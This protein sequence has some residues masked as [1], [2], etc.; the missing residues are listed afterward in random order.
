MDFP[1]FNTNIEVEEVLA[2]MR[3]EQEK[4]LAATQFTKQN[5]Y[6]PNKY[7]RASL[8]KDED[9][10][11]LTIRLLPF[12]PEGGSP[13]KKIFMHT[14]RVSSEVAKSTWKTIACPKHNEE[15]ENKNCPF[16]EMS[17]MAKQKSRE[18]LDEAKK[19][20]LDDLS[21]VNRASEMWLVR[22]I[23]RGKENEGVKF[24]LFPNPKKGGVFQD[25]MTIYNTRKLAGERKGENRNIFDLSKGKDLVVTIKR[26]ADNKK[27]VTVVDDDDWTSLTDN[28]ELGNSWITD[29]TKWTDLYPFKRE[30]YMNVLV[31]GGVPYFDKDTKTYINKDEYMAKSEAKRNEEDAQRAAQVTECPID[32]TVPSPI[33]DSA[34]VANAFSVP[35]EPIKTE[36]AAIVEQVDDFS[37]IPEP[38]WED[39]LPF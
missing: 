32:Y 20:R 4:K 6:D 38:S 8:A 1:N 39:D 31:Q 11:T 28:V 2:Q 29:S 35:T 19:K 12:R 9:E 22:C 5:D 7:L 34:T 36:T 37:S 21:Y 25:I 24:W 17:A 3:A 30:D 14:I 13:F 16:C 26:G 23:E 33:E 15:S 27:K 18:T 10:K